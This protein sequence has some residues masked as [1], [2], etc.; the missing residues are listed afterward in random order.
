M[1]QVQSEWLLLGPKLQHHPACVIED[2]ANRG[3][4]GNPKNGE[5]IATE[6]GGFHILT[7]GCHGY[8]TS[9]AVGKQTRQSK[10][11]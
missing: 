1:K 7:W 6:N 3:K 8:I 5:V 4:L 2:Q 10:I 11:L 9:E